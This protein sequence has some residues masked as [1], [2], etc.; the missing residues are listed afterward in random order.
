MLAHTQKLFFKVDHKNQPQCTTCGILFKI[1]MLILS[2]IY[3]F[4][5]FESAQQGKAHKIGIKVSRTLCL[6]KS[7][8]NETEAA[9]LKCICWTTLP[10]PVQTCS[11][12]VSTSINVFISNNKVIFSVLSLFLIFLIKWLECLNISATG[13]ARVYSL[14]QKTLL[15]SDRCLR[16]HIRL[17]P[18]LRQI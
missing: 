3:L 4:V 5:C 13:N 10:P 1:I 9:D 8:W 2:F 15:Y 17:N 11:G 6:Q 16:H 14:H 7:S 12:G 18:S